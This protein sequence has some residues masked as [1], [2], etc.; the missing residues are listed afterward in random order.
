MG[1]IAP[2]TQSESVRSSS[3]KFRWRLVDVCL[4]DD[5]IDML[6]AIRGAL[7]ADGT[8]RQYVMGVEVDHRAAKTSTNCFLVADFLYDTMLSYIKVDFEIDMPLS[9]LIVK[10]YGSKGDK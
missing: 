9:D 1:V 7:M 3:G 4:T 6:N 2:I 5:H 8:I 10:M